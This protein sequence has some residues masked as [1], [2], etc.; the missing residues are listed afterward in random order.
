M[1]DF[2][3]YTVIDTISI[4]LNCV[5]VDDQFCHI[6]ASIF[7][8]NKK[9]DFRFIINFSQRIAFIMFFVLIIYDILRVFNARQYLHL[10]TYIYG[11]MI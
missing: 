11:I 3:D 4:N 7:K 6:C 9:K 8:K 1:L 10:F 5:D 2:K